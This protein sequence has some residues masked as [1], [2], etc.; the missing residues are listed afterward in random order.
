MTSYSSDN[1]F[2]WSKMTSYIREPIQNIKLFFIYVNANL[3]IDCVS[4]D[5]ETLLNMP[6]NIPT[7][8]SKERLLHIIQN[9]RHHNNKKYRLDDI[10]SFQI[11]LEPENIQSFSSASASASACSIPTSEFDS[12]FLKS[13]PMFDDISCIPSI[14][15]FHDIASLYFLFHEID[16]SRKSILKNGHNYNCNNSSRMTKKVQINND[17]IYDNNKST[18][19]KSIK[20]FMK[21]MK[22]TRKSFMPS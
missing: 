5:V 7:T 21:K 1:D 12:T 8:I 17:V 18:N 11:H 22:L 15:I 4:K 9:K 6:S 14:F 2:A 3:E 19:N 10:L 20:K 13:I 16:A